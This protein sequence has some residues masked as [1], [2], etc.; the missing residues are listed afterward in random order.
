MSKS[1][2]QIIRSVTIRRRDSCAWMTPDGSTKCESEMNFDRQV[3]VTEPEWRVLQ[4]REPETGRGRTDHSVCAGKQGI[5]ET[6]VVVIPT[7]DGY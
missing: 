7:E 6:D 1:F 5:Q 3:G 4:A 2:S